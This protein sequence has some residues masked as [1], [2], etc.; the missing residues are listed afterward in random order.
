MKH[1]KRQVTIKLLPVP[2][3]PG[4]FKGIIANHW[5]QFY[6]PVY[7]YLHS[8]HRLAFFV[9]FFANVGYFLRNGWSPR[10]RSHIK[11]SININMY[12]PVYQ[13]LIVLYILQPEV[14]E[15][16]WSRPSGPLLFMLRYFTNFFIILNRLYLLIKL[17][18]LKYSVCI[19]TIVI[20][21]WQMYFPILQQ[22]CR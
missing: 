8:Y 2:R 19:A 17:C 18:L 13:L 7:H 3:N 20:N 6:Q 14:L 10:S 21:E 11:S 12:T 22:L 5:S 9:C 1:Y 15:P 4:A 16:V